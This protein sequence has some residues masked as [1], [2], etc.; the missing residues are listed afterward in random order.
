MADII[1]V[2]K[3]DFILEE[4]EAHDFTL[5]E[6]DL[7]LSF[8]VGEYTTI[9]TYDYNELNNKPKINGYEVIGEKLG[10]DYRLQDQ[11]DEITPQEIDFIIFG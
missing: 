3:I 2:K 4:S 11:M 5:E 9:G 7:D 1:D 6:N 8:G 10:R